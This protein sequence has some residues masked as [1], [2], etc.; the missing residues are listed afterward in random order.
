MVGWPGEII[1]LLGTH[2]LSSRDADVI[3]H[4]YLVEP[5]RQL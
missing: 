4:K 1:N 3:S 5:L 2:K